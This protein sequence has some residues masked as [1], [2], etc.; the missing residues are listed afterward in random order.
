[1]GNKSVGKKFDRQSSKPVIS[2]IDLK[3]F[4]SFGEDPKGF[5]ESRIRNINTFYRF[6]IL[7][8]N[9]VKIMSFFIISNC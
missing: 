3:Q 7:H 2:E 8:K 4:K 1:M 9:N 6:L 5:I